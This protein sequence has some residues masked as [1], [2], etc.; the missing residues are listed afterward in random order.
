MLRIRGLDYPPVQRRK[1]KK[2]M[3]SHGCLAK[4]VGRCVLLFSVGISVALATDSSTL[5]NQ[6]DSYKEVSIE[7]LV[8]IE[9]SS[10][11]KRPERLVDVPSA[12]Q[13]ITAE[14]IHRSGATSLPE[15]LRLASNLE[16]AQIDSRQWAISARGFNAPLANKLLVLIDGRVVYTPLFAGVFWDVQNVMLEDIDRIEVISGPGATLWGANAVNGV[17]NVISKTAKETQGGLIT[18]GGGSFEH[19]F[20]SIRYGGKLADDVY[21]RVYGMGFERDRSLTQEKTG[22]GDRWGL[23]QAGFRTDWLPERGDKATFQGDFYGGRIEQQNAPDL[24]VDGQ[25]IVGRFTHPFSAESDATLQVF[26]DRTWRRIPATFTEDL[27]TLDIDFQNRISLLERHKLIWGFE[28][29]LS[30]DDVGNSSLLAFLPPEKTLNLFSGFV[31][32]EIELIDKKLFLTVGSKVEHNEYSG[33]EVQ[34]SGRLAYKPVENQTIWGAVSRAVRS[35]SRIDTEYFVPGAAPYFV[36]GGG[37]RFKSEELLAYE[38]GYRVEFNSRVSGSVSTFFNDYD[39]VR[40]V[41]PIPGSPGQYIILNELK[42]QAYGA[43]FSA[44]YRVTDW[45]KLRGGYTLFKKHVSVEAADINNGAGEGNDPHH[46]FLLQS[47]LTLP[48]DVDFD[49]VIRFVDTLNQPGP[50]VPAYL[51]MDLRLAWRPR[52]DLEFSV[53]GQNLLDDQH[54][55]FGAP[56]SRLEIPRGVYGKVSWQF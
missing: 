28:Y 39:N 55:E 51:T 45:W 36:Q 29:R 41:E 46:Q 22:A 6:I 54:P 44:I 10:V 53:V 43:E 7:D 31:Q 4:R 21:Y 9:V 24:H 32:D 30:L 12:I 47:M 17:I 38:L 34:P 13:I 35:P 11:S 14:D 2:L 26:W 33:I 16:V 37:K 15:A 27:N 23:G 42:A 50:A 19:G 8:N 5:T 1:T 56:A 52:K 18:G 48:H 49:T 25:N 3:I 20:G 40:S